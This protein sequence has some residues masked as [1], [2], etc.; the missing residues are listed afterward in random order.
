MCSHRVVC[1]ILTITVSSSVE[2][3][4]II[5]A[6]QQQGYNVKNNSGL[7]TKTRN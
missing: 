2:H 3:E 4:V 6:N 7:T 5:L 1:F